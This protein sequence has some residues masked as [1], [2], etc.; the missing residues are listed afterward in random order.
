MTYHHV[1]EIGAGDSHSS[2]GL[3]LAGQAELVTLYEPNAILRADLMRAAEGRVNVVVR[4]EAIRNEAG[5]GTLYHL[6]YG[7]FLY[8]APAFLATSIEPD[9]HQ[10]LAPLARQVPCQTMRNVDPGDIDLLIVTTG[11]GEYDI[12]KRLVSRPAT[13]ETAHYCHSPVQWADT[14]RT[15]GWL[16]RAGYRGEVVARNTH[17][18]F[19]RIRWSLTR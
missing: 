17:S 2:Q 1:V 18:T 16:E 19:H 3:R 12:L 8:G 10:W 14:N 13:I 7:S 4:E 15:I 9:Y 5:T 11:G 6:G